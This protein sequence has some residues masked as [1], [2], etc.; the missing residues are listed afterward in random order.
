MIN[1]KCSQC[2]E[3]MEAP[4]SLQGSSLKCPMCQSATKIPLNKPS[5]QVPRKTGDIL[6]RIWKN[7]PAPFRTA[8]LATLGVFAALL[9]GWLAYGH[10]FTT[11]NDFEKC[12]AKLENNNLFFTSTKSGIFRG[13]SL[14]QFLFSPDVNY[15]TPNLSLWCDT[16]GAVVG[17]SASYYG[18]LNG[19]HAYL[20][21]QSASWERSNKVRDGFES[22][23]NY[24]T[25]FSNSDFITHADGIDE[26]AFDS[27]KKWN[28]Q[29]HRAKTYEIGSELHLQFTQG[30]D[31]TVYHFL[32]TAQTW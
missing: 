14:Q 7:S 15:H 12:K 3:K 11:T 26:I 29:A 25:Y 31:P 17:I 22:I 1:F 30:K 28:I 27:H 21:N 8:F 24:N 32:V 9:V 5:K 19:F 23:V 20:T 6:I 2:G 4:E 13:R 10:I 18:T 16:D